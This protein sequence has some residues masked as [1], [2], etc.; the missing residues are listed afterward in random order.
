[1]I[2]PAQNAPKGN[3]KPRRYAQG[4][5]NLPGIA[6]SVTPAALYFY[7]TTRINRKQDKQKPVLVFIFFT[8]RVT[9]LQRV[10]CYNAA[11]MMSVGIFL[12]QEPGET[13]RQND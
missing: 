9:L 13:T 8:F 4:S 11:Q 7:F 6:R 5:G 1:V 2:R 3:K 12:R 10:V